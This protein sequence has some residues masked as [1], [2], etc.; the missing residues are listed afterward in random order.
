MLSSNEAL[1]KLILAIYV[2]NFGILLACTYTYSNDKS[3]NNETF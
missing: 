3:S 1:K 2:Y